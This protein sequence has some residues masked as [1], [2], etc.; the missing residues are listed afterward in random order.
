MVYTFSFFMD[1]KIICWNC[2]GAASSKFSAILQNILRYHK[3]DILVSPEMR[4][5]GKKV[6]E[7]IRRTK[8]DCSFRVEAKGF[9]RMRI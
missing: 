8:F 4:I 7:V 5:S 3:L 9:S 6:D 1:I 2:Q